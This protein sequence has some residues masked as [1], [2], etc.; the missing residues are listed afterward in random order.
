MSH[1]PPCCS[2]DLGKQ[3]KGLYSISRGAYD[4]CF[5]ILECLGLAFAPYRESYT[6]EPFLLE[7]AV[8]HL[9]DALACAH[10]LEGPVEAGVVF[11]A[12]GQK[13]ERLCK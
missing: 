5:G 12:E 11:I 8:L 1:Q 10:H 6:P 7:V 13:S 3:F 9:I 4:H 2:H